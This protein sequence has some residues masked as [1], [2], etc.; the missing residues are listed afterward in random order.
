MWFI[1]IYTNTSLVYGPNVK[2]N[3]RQMMLGIKN[4]WFP[5]LPKMNN[6]RSM[7]HID[8][9]VRA[10]L[11][12]AISDNTKG[13]ILN[14]LLETMSDSRHLSFISLIV[15]GL[16]TIHVIEQKFFSILPH[17]LSPKVLMFLVMLK[18]SNSCEFVHQLYD[19]DLILN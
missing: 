9:V 15:Y 10:I 16:I 12:V 4:G 18:R 19:A 1:I 14:K 6:K 13:E 8:D 7:V 5:P 3:L 2:G 17:L 11:F